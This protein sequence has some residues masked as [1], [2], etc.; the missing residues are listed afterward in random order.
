MSRELAVIPAR[1]ASSRYPG[2]PLVPILGV[3]MVVRVARIA[4]EALGATNVVVATED[5]RIARVVEA[6]G[7]RAVMTSDRCLTGTDRLAE[8]AELIEADVYVNVQGDEPML[9]PETI[10][11][12]VTTASATPG[13]IHNGMC[14]LGPEEDPA[15]VNIPKVVATESGRL[16][17]MSRAAL[18]ASKDARQ[19]PIVY[20]KQVCIYTFSGEQLRAFAAFGR[21]AVIESHEDI[22][23]L[24]F[25]E[26]GY[27]VQ[28]VA[29]DGGSL[30][31]DV[32]QDVLLVEE[33]MRTRGVT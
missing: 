25:L 26:L 33:A 16:L 4:A 5:S 28:M 31:V 3:P 7:F 32:P 9:K 19:R 1:Y 2:K 8:V 21:K 20:W 12:V 17:Y 22:E 27:P 24:R 10:C 11:Q 14:R 23:I 15:N 6:A 13:V 30:A 18:P 29:V